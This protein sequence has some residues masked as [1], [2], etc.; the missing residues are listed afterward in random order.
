MLISTFKPAGVRPFH[1]PDGRS[2]QAKA[3]E[4]AEDLFRKAAEGLQDMKPRDTA[5]LNDVVG[6]DMRH[7][8]DPDQGYPCA[9]VCLFHILLG[10]GVKQA[11]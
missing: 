9:F 6:R 7:L 4:P 2:V 8:G 10:R 5:A 3:A 11:E 1:A